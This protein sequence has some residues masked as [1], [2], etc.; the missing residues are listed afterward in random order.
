MATVMAKVATL[1]IIQELSTN[2]EHEHFVR[3]SCDFAKYM[4][5]RVSY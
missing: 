2:T 1:M 4:H 3:L 5:I